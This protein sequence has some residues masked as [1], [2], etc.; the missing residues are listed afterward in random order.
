MRMKRITTYSYSADSDTINVATILF[1]GWSIIYLR[2]SPVTGQNLCSL[3]FRATS[4]P[5]KSFFF[6]CRGEVNI[7]ILGPGPTSRLALLIPHMAIDVSLHYQWGS[8]LSSVSAGLLREDQSWLCTTCKHV[9]SVRRIVRIGEGSFRK[10]D[11]SHTKQNER[12]ML[13]WPWDFSTNFIYLHELV[14]KPKWLTET[15][16]SQN[17]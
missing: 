3:G 5:S 14:W 9:M 11:T 4:W 2:G 6:F 15:F 17:I 12:S 13:K 16:K 8:W 10:K 7:H 1:K